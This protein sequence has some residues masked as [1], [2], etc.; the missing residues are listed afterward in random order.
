MVTP[1]TIKL[2]LSF[3]KYKWCPQSLI[4]SIISEKKLLKPAVK[5]V[6][7][8]LPRFSTFFGV[9]LASKLGYTTRSH[10]Q[11]QHKYEVWLTLTQMGGT[12]LT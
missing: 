11:N 10:Y 12:L 6:V 3:E 5:L 2:T 8:F 4:D 7:P 1:E 9:E